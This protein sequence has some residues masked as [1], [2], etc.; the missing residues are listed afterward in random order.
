MHLISDLANIFRRGLYVSGTLFECRRCGKGYRHKS[1]LYK[2]T[3][4]ECGLEGQFRCK[5]C[6]HVS[7]QKAHFVHHMF[8]RHAVPKDALNDI[9]LS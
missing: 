8:S 6:H 2:H 7:K 3:K 4:W 9:R 1:S 5:I